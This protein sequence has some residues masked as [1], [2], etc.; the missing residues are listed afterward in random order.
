[1]LVYLDGVAK[2]S[3]GIAGTISQSNFRLGA[4]IDTTSYNLQGSLDDVRVYNRILS[5]NEVL[6][7]YNT[8]A[9]KVKASNNNGLVGYWSFDDCRKD[10]ATDSSGYGNTGTLTNFALS[11]ATSNWTT[12]G[13][14]GCALKF[15]G[16]DDYVQIADSSSLD[17]A[18]GTSYSYGMWIKTTS[19]ANTVLMEKGTNGFFMLQPVPAGVDLYINT[20]DTVTGGWSGF[21]DGRWHH[22]F[23]TY[24]ASSN[25]AT[26]YKDGAS[27]G[28]VT[29]AGGSSAN[30]NVLY[31][32][33][34]A[35]SYAIDAT[36]DDVRIYN[37]ALSANEV[38]SLYNAY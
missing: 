5:A 17:S 4:G 16:T 35:G 14:R 29:S 24:N 6:A 34:R 23:V 27:I 33:S 38:R 13:K 12:A 18:G 7:L 25:T 10:K 26:L 1:L 20:V 3:S 15:D 37:R 36:I 28:V 2:S 30:N 31:I 21:R 32:G 22:L 9:A 11:G 19:S 8:G